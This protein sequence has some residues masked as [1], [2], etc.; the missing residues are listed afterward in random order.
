[1]NMNQV[2]IKGSD[3]WA[4]KCFA[5]VNDIRFYLNE[6]AKMFEASSV[7]LVVNDACVLGEIKVVELVEEN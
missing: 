5:S 7:F 3:I 2:R 4:I 6:D 1:M